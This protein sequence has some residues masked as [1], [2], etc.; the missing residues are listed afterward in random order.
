MKQPHLC[1]KVLWDMTVPGSTVLAEGEIVT[2]IQ[3]PAPAAGVKSA[4]I[5]FAIGKSLDFPMA[6]RAAAIGE[7]NTRVCP[8]AMHN[9]LHPAGKAEIHQ[10]QSH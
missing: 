1:R 4:F 5:K 3:L 6:N 8:N 2:E 9:K 10:G 7:I